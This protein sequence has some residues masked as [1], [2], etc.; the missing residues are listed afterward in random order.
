VSAPTPTGA[1]FALLAADAALARLVPGGAWLDEEPEENQ[2]G[3]SPFLVVTHQGM[4]PRY[5]SEPTATLEETRLRL[6]A[7][8]S[9]DVTLSPTSPAHPAEAAER[10][11]YAL[12]DA[13]DR[14]PV[15]VANS[16]SLGLVRG[17]YRLAKDPRRAPDG[18]RVYRVELDVTITV[19]RAIPR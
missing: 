11:G 6:T 9:R 15:D 2:I 5:S 8:A 13:L 19:Q 12:C 7:Y 10:I 16:A 4:T 14:Q 17:P 3:V 18:G 1:L